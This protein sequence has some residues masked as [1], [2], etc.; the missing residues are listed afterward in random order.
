MSSYHYWNYWIVLKFMSLGYWN[1]WV[2]IIILINYIKIVEYCVW[3]IVVESSNLRGTLP[4][5][6]WN[7]WILGLI[8]ELIIMESPN[9]RKD[10]IEFINCWINCYIY[11]FQIWQAKAEVGRGRMILA[12]LHKHPPL[13]LW[14]QLPPLP[15]LPPLHHHRAHPHGLQ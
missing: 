5:L 7:C 15:C 11:F 14:I 9:L 2:T 10:F 12:L 13:L 4:K 1:L 6:C 3:L 8:V